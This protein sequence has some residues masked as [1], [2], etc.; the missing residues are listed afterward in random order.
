MTYA[1]DLRAT[2]VTTTEFDKLD[3]LTASTSELNIMDGVTATTSELNI[4]DGVTASTSELNIMDGVTATASE[5]NIMD[6]VTASTAE[7]NIMDGVTATA[8]EINLIDGNTARGTTT[9]ASGDGFLHNDGGTM[10]MTNISK[11]A[12]R[13]AGSGL[14]ASDGVISSSASTGLLSFS[15]QTMSGNGIILD[16]NADITL[17]ADGEDIFLKDDG[18]T[19]GTLKNFNTGLG[20]LGGTSTSQY[21]IVTDSSGNLTTG[22]N[23]PF[24]IA[25]GMTNLGSSSAE[26]LLS[27][28]TTNG[29]TISGTDPG[30]GFYNQTFT[31]PFDCKLVS[32]I[33]S[34][35]KSITNSSNLGTFTLSKANSGSD[36]FADL[37]VVNEAVEDPHTPLTDWAIAGLGT[38]GT[39]YNFLNF[40]AASE[41]TGQPATGSFGPQTF[42]QGDKISGSMKVSSSV[43]TSIRGSWTFVFVSTGGL[44]LAA[45][46]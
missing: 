29:N 4:M 26:K 21:T 18:T 27:F 7:L 31:V 24:V 40:S 8:A 16:S 42:S 13:L 45:S 12:D 43:N 10:R 39:I 14:S 41:G 1:K 38:A 11:L 19:F 32:V 35:D 23:F 44:E 20:I 22:T 33:G 46:E 37:F 6:G 17:D 30:D 28:N 3:G 9:V 36:N 5:L 34:F 15:D 2:G 25:A